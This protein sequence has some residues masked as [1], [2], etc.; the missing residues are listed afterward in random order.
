[1]NLVVLQIKKVQEKRQYRVREWIRSLGFL[2]ANYSSSP[3]PWPQKNAVLD[4][5]CHMAQLF[6]EN[7]T[8]VFHWTVLLLF[9]ADIVQ[10]LQLLAGILSLCSWMVLTRPVLWT[11]VWLVGFA[12][13][14]WLPLMGETLKSAQGLYAFVLLLPKGTVGVNVSRREARDVLFSLKGR[15]IN[16]HWLEFEIVALYYL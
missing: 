14:T 7:I 4:F 1:M 2:T 9:P 15:P 12:W 8:Y 3:S 6:Q 10:A 5:T 13:R 11:Q 16:Y